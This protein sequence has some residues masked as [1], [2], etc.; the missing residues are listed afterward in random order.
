MCNQQ[1]HKKES[2]VSFQFFSHGDWEIFDGKPSGEAIGKD[3]EL[4]TRKDEELATR[5][6]EEL[7]TRKEDQQATKKEAQQATRKDYLS[8]EVVVTSQDMLEDDQ[9][10]S[11]PG[12]LLK[13][14]NFLQKSHP[15]TAED[16][17]LGKNMDIPGDTSM[18]NLSDIVPVIPMALLG[19]KLLGVVT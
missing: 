18:E 13:N 19:V 10:D 15:L 9:V 7:A 6:D 17:P 12:Q 3:E 5:K 1:F 2:D 8:D 16:I 4:A 11:P 14:E